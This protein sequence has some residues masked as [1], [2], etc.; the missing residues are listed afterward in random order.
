MML[1]EE[2]TVPE[3]ALPVASFKEHLRLGSGFADADLQDGLLVSYL[4]AAVA[5][6]EARTGKILIVRNFSWRLNAWRDG[7]R[8]MLPIAPVSEVTGITLVDAAGVET[9][10]DPTLWTLAQDTHRPT[11]VAAKSC[12]PTIPTSGAALIAMQAGYAAV[13]AELPNDLAQAVIL[14]AA[15]YYEVRHEHAGG[16]PALPADVQALIA[17]HRAL[18]LFAG[19]RT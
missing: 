14:L 16:A 12:L 1:V 18:R 5:T 11:L 15:H 13:W 4:R 17:P 19:G 7:Q 10:A 6:I 8:Q 9:A 3:S 2:T